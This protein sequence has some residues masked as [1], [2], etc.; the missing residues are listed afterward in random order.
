MTL[1]IATCNQ[2]SHVITVKI[3]ALLY[4][5]ITGN[6]TVP[7]VVLYASCDYI[8]KNGSG[9]NQLHKQHYMM[10]EHIV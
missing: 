10:P 4:F 3:S 5:L 8:T 2:Q 9:A 7:M 6:K 1:L